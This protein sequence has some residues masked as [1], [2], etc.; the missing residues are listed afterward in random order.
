MPRMVLYEAQAFV[1]ASEASLGIH[2]VVDD[3][4]SGMRQISRFYVLELLTS[5]KNWI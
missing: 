1:A 4:P 3:L 5:A 2:S